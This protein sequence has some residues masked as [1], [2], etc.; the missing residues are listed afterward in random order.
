M[1][2]FFCITLRFFLFL[3]WPEVER[4]QFYKLGQCEKTTQLFPHS[5]SRCQPVTK[6]CSF[7][8][9]ARTRDNIRQELSLKSSRSVDTFFYMA[10]RYTVLDSHFFYFAELQCSINSQQ[11]APW[12]RCWIQWI[13]LQSV[14]SQLGIFFCNSVAQVAFFWKQ[15]G[16]KWGQRRGERREAGSQARIRPCRTPAS[17]YKKSV[18]PGELSKCSPSASVHEGLR[19][20]SSNL[21]VQSKSARTRKTENKNTCSLFWR[22]CASRHAHIQDNVDRNEHRDVSVFMKP[23]IERHKKKKSQT[24]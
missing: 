4:R 24:K 8:Y 3:Q 7:I 10:E 9:E 22:D 15:F 1:N 21:W 5:I 23:F 11:G 2:Y 16:R 13:T 20:P 14:W 17:L 18:P 6:I 12:Q 19:G